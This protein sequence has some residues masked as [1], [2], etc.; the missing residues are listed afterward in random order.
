MFR[1]GS[2]SISRSGGRRAE[3]CKEADGGYD[4]AEAKE[5]LHSPKKIMCI[6]G[7]LVFVQ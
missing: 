2:R 6:R 7:I 1:L 5:E 4:A 3:Q